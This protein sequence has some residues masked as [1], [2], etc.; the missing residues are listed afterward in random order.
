MKRINAVFGKKGEEEAKKFL[1]D[2]GFEILAQNYRSPFGEVDLVCKDKNELVFVEVKT[3]R[4]LE[5]G[6]GAE[7]VD[8]KKQEKIMKTAFYFLKNQRLEAHPFRFDV[9]SILSGSD[10]KISYIPR[11][12]P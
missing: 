1:Q 8:R 4:N 2:K 10:L 12:F 11:A 7:A 5:F 6:D 3:R 9:V